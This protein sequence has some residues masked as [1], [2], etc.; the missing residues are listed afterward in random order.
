MFFRAGCNSLLAVQSATPQRRNLTVQADSVRVRNQQY[1][2]D[3]RRMIRKDER[4]HPGNGSFD[5]ICECTAL[6]PFNDE[7][8]TGLFHGKTFNFL[9]E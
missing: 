7:K 4:R 9:N 2:L 8:D 5:L 3:E 1:S 6:C